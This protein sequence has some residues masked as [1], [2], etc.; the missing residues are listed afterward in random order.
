MRNTLRLGFLIDAGKR[1]YIT[2]PHA[3]TTLLDS[4]VKTAMEGIIAT[5]IVKTSNGYLAAAETA[6]LFAVE[7][8]E[9]NVA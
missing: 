3:K 7:T 6:S 5:D 9:L 4:D 1:A 2:I 8:V